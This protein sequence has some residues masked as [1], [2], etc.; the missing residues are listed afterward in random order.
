MAVITISLAL[1]I[2]FG[3]SKKEL[4]TCYQTVFTKLLSFLYSHPKFPLTIAFTGESLEYFE[5]SHPAALEILRELTSRKQVEI[6]GGGYYSPIFPLLFPVDRSGQIEM[7]SGALR[8]LIGKRPRGMTLFG[9][10]WDPALITT[11]SSSM[12]YVYLDST[13]IPSSSKQ[14]LPIIVSEQGKNLKVLPVYKSFVPEKDEDEN[15]WL[16]RIEKAVSKTQEPGITEREDI[17]NIVT[18]PIPYESFSDFFESKV[19]SYLTYI[20][21]ESEEGKGNIRLSV[22]HVYFKNACKFVS[23][24]IPAGMDWQIAQ[25][26]RKLYKKCENKSRFPITIYDFLNMYRPVRNLYERMMDLSVLLSPQSL[27]SCKQRDKQ[28][29][30]QRIKMA[31]ELL[32]EAQCGVH[33]IA[34]PSGVPAT[35][36]KR[37]AAYKIL[38]TAEK[39]RREGV[40]FSEAMASFD[41]NGDGLNEYVCRFTDMHLVLSRRAGMV[42]SLDVLPCGFNY[43]S[44]LSRFQLFDN[45][46]D[47]YE[48]GL[49]VEHLLSEQEMKSYVQNGKVESK[50]FTRIL[51]DEK[52]FDHRR[53]EIQMEGRAEFSAMRMP[54]LL[55]KN[56]IVDSS[57]ISVQYILKN[58]SPFPVDGIFIVESTFPQT[59]FSRPMKTGQYELELVLDENRKE[60]SGN[61]P[62][63]ADGGVS[64]LRVTDK[65]GKMQFNFEP[66]EESGLVVMPLQFNRPDGAENIVPCS[67]SVAVSFFWKVNMAPNRA[68]EKTVNFAMTRVK[69]A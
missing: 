4:E 22:P 52:K 54:I 12:E 49:F 34:L 1:Q 64:M 33:Y 55:R 40:N 29:D 32:W 66:N 62:F 59:N 50:V 13:L 44:S 31:Q 53:R 27:R 10:I 9:S 68:I 61:A 6:F 23:S 47:A 35:E 16:S 21:D 17:N 56:Y 20:A 8:R 45:V 42:S 36:E 67:T 63:S 46:E 41:Y 7:L 15:V 30:K 51:F 69:K 58:E 57:T 19:F 43:A 11:F 28:R 18:I 24:Y 25:W 14:F 65:G 39:I 60:V 5:N 3:F 38:D 2:P 48:R 26:S 37:Q